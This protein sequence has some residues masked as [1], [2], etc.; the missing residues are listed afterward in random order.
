M[1][2]GGYCIDEDTRENDTMIS[3]NRIRHFTRDEFQD[4][5]F[6]P[7]SGDLIDGEF[8]AMIIRLRIDTGW[9]MMV[10]WQVGGAVDVEGSY[11]H[12]DESY[13]LKNQGCKAIDF[14]FL[15]EAPFNRQFWE[16]A[17]TGFAGIGFYPQWIHPGWHIDKRPIEEAFLWK[18]VNR[19]YVYFL[20]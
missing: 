12:A 5:L 20:Q 3:W 16:I 1:Y 9:P 4:P 18:F 8:L 14:H 15:T 13:H 11:G 17:H 10:H 7:E 19:K 2:S 6:G